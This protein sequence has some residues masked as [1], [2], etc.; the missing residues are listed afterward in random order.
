MV[1]VEVHSVGQRSPLRA[2]GPKLAKVQCVD[3]EPDDL[4][5]DT[6]NVRLA[7]HVLHVSDTLLGICTGC[8]RS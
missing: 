7:F 2:F 1:F 5:P 3:F 8:Q 4:F 6:R